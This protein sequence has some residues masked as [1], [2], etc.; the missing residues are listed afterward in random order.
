MPLTF[1]KLAL[2]IFMCLFY[3]YHYYG[4]SPEQTIVLGR[5]VFEEPTAL[6]EVYYLFCL[7]SNLSDPEQ[8]NRKVV[9]K[10]GHRNLK[11][12]SLSLGHKQFPVKA[13]V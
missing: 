1:K 11:N 12:F 13:Q 4:P 5:A 10:Q 8:P 7:K 9:E 3:Y 2:C 6:Q